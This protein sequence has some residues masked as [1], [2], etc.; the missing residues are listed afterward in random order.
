MKF[1]FNGYCVTRKNGKFTCAKVHPDK[2]ADAYV[3]TIL[4]GE[5]EA[6]KKLKNKPRRY[7]KRRKEMV[8]VLR[9]CKL[10]ILFFYS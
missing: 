5:N 9:K 7:K 10:S 6:L 3:S 8:E 2:C 4:E 1:E